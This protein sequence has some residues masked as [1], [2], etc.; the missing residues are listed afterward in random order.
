MNQARQ[1][2]LPQAA[3]CG[4]TLIELLVVIAIIAI[5]AAMLLPALAKARARGQAISCLNNVRQLSFANHMY[6]SDFNGY[7]VNY[8][9][10]Q[11][12]WIDRL[13]T[14]AASKQATSAPVRICPVTVKSGT[15]AIVPPDP[16]GSANTFWGPLANPAWGTGIGS[17]G[18]YA[19]NAWVYSSGDP[20]GTAA[21]HCGRA[22]T[23]RDP[24]NVPFMG[25]AIWMDTWVRVSDTLPA[26]SL[27]GD[28]SSAGLGRFAI[29]RHTQAINLAFMDGS[30]RSCKL[31]RLK[32]LHW[33][34]EPGWP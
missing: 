13:A 17:S 14:Y 19:M 5:L 4:F 28:F 31:T 34:E 1:T 3:R 8:D 32:T 2:H 11:G 27:N 12:L 26:D 7:S 18:A 23:V 9:Q 25:D 20:L 10:N 15:L 22:E 29:N 30:A 33:S 21:Y 24:S 6:L 16:V